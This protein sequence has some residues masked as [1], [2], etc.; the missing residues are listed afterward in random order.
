M[1]E[2]SIFFL[3]TQEHNHLKRPAFCLADLST[4]IKQ[5]ERDFDLDTKM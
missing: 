5:T 3:V 1:F 4:I 2:L